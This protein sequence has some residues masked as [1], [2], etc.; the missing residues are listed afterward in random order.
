MV[1]SALAALAIAA[2]LAGGASYGWYKGSEA[3]ADQRNKSLEDGTFSQTKGWFDIKHNDSTNEKAK[4]LKQ[5]LKDAGLDM[6]FIDSMSDKE[7]AAYA[8]EFMNED[9]DVLGFS[10]K[11]F[12]KDSFLHDIRELQDIENSWQEAPN[13]PDYE[14][15][16]RDAAKTINQENAELS[17]L[18]DKMLNRQTANYQQQMDDLNSSY[19]DYSRQILSNDYIQNAQ[20]MNTVSSSLSKSRQNA[21][22]AGA[23]AGLRLANNVN[24]LLST[25]NQQTAQSLQTSNNLAQMLLNQRQAAAGI[26]NDYNNALNQNTMNK[27][28]LKAGTA[29]RTDSYARGQLDTAN[30]LYQNKLNSWENTLNAKTGSNV[31]GDAYKTYKSQSANKY[32]Y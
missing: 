11:T 2:A 32:G 25:Q 30:T 16:Y 15:I 28:N 12:D 17:A 4:F 31:F 1:I 23:S 5:Y 19:R 27:A 6:G 8:D 14:Q 20:L 9:Y 29:E 13:A 22:Q 7:L 3:N 18:Y 26:R 21:L 10:S 24:T